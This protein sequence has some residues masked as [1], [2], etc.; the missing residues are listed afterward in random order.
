MSAKWLCLILAVVGAACGQVEVGELAPTVRLA[1]QSGKPRD[2]SASYGRWAVLAFYPKDDTPG[3]TKEAINVNANLDQLVAAGIDVYGVSVQDVDSK[4]AFCTKYG[5]KQTM[6]SDVDKSVCKAYG[7][8]NAHGMSD[9]VT[10]I[11][12][13]SRTIRVIDR[14]VNVSTHGADVLKAVTD[15]QAADAKTA[16]AQLA[17]DTTDTPVGKLRLPEGWTHSPVGAMW[18]VDGPNGLQIRLR[19]RDAATLP[20]SEP[21][22]EKDFQGGQVAMAEA[23]TVAGHPG[24]R[25]DGH[26][27]RT[28]FYATLVWSD[29][30]KGN[31][32]V[33]SGNGDSWVELRRLAAAIAATISP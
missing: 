26:G 32:L 33:V 31:E 11:L 2:V 12:D 27:E 30:Q 20:A 15:L 24:F 19:N 29:G 1:D 8:L 7:T 13:P 17:A 9:R 22:A 25:Y 10:F 3:C 16:L 21:D 18:K 14:K 28:R 23:V 4:A 6:L 5:L